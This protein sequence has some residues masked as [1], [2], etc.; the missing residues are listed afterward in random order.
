MSF[1]ELRWAAALPRNLVVGVATLGP[2][3]RA[4][5]APGTWGSLA[6]TVFFAAALS[7]VHTPALVVVS[8]VLALFAVVFCGEAERRLGQKDP[9]GVVLDEF[10]AMP[11]CFLG[12]RE[13]TLYLP[14]WQVLLLGFGFFR[15]FDI[16]KPLGI[17]RL[18]KLPGGWG[19][20]VD[21]LV[22]ALATCAT[23]HVVI[24]VR[25]LLR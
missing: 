13:L 9:G 23:L 15:F 4:K 20:V 21:D 25:S 5:W 11:L 10:V 24:G 6:G 14:W 16:A 7:R 1:P 3:G 8:L 22:A 19:V 2:V 18:Q 17:R 12:W